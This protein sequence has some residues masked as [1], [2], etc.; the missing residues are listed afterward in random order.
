MPTFIRKEPFELGNTARANK[1]VRKLLLESNK[2]SGIM[3]TP[4]ADADSFKKAT[5]MLE[6]VETNIETYI[7]DVI[8]NLN[9]PTQYAV[10]T[11]AFR[12]K[13]VTLRKLVYSPKF[14]LN[15][16]PL[17]DVQKLRNYLQ[18]YQNFS[19]NLV[20]ILE[21]NPGVADD[22]LEDI[23][24]V[25]EYMKDII[26]YLK[27]RI[28]IY[29]SGVTQPVTMKGGCCLQY[30]LGQPLRNSSMYQTQRYLFPEYN[31]L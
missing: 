3:G 14:S 6:T 22:L 2:S 28:D 25:Y 16:I 11:E 5:D 9:G 7:Q 23:N 13:I 4:V 20:D 1:K 21:D 18:S 31:K 29:D 15:L 8:A 10:S 30:D 19:G 27:I 24:F 26:K 17:D 12:N